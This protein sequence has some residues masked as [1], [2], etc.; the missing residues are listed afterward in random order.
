MSEH[1]AAYAGFL[2]HISKP[3]RTD[4]RHTTAESI[5]HIR[6]PPHFVSLACDGLPTTSR[7]PTSTFRPLR[8]PSHP[9]DLI[10]ALQV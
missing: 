8:P 7:L 3:P 2:S 5:R 6:A 4:G 10:C 1:Q 9:N